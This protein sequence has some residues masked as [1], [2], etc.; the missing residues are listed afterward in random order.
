MQARKNVK[1]LFTILFSAVLCIAVF[2]SQTASASASGYSFTIEVEGKSYHLNGEEIGIYKGNRYIK[3]L[4]GVVDGIFYD[5]ATFCKDASLTFT[6]N[7]IEPFKFSSERAGRGINKEKLIE[8][9]NSAL[10]RGENFAR[11]SFIELF[12]SVTVEDLKKYTYKMA[13]FSTYYGSSGNSRKHNIKL[14][15][16]KINGTVLKCGEEFSFNETVGNRTEDN[17]FLSATVIENGEFSEGVGGG[18]CQVSTTLYNCVLT[19]GLKVTK[20]Y[21]HSIQPV[22]VEPSFDAMVSGS[23]FDLK[24]INDTGGNVYVKAVADGNL[25]TF[26]LYGEKP[27]ATYQRVSKTVEI[28]P[29]PEVEIIEDGELEVG[30]SEWVKFSKNGLKSEGYL[31]VIDANGNVSSIKLHTDVY[32]TVRGQLK[33]GTKA[34]D[35]E[36]IIS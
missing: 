36:E 3:C 4:E 24:F 28:I 31:K 25:V 17:G 19:A 12:P 35:K 2:L 6:P 13:E 29:A 34:V 7:E 16:S 8:D 11:A 22:Y 27:S 33:V 9:I 26:T 18:V 32:K 15:V 14:A 5:T 23:A 21:A 30:V 20:R 1:S 10:K